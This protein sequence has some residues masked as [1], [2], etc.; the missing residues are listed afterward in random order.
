M[1]DLQQM[2]A[3]LEALPDPAFILSRSGKYI[4]VF[5]GRDARYYHDGTGLIGKYISDLVKPDKAEWF[6]EQI[7]RALES[8]KLLVEEYEL[9]N[10][11]V[12]GLPDEGPEDP[13]WFEGRI[14]ALDFQVDGEPLVLWVASNISERH[15]LEIRLRELS[16]TDQLTGLFNRRKL[17]HDL[18]LHFETFTRHA[19]PTTVLIFDV[20]NLKKINDSKGHHVGDEVL[21]A[22]ANTCRSELRKTDI[23]CRFGG[24][25]FVVCLPNTAPDR[26]LKFAERLQQDLRQALMD[27]SVGDI[28]ATI[29]LGA[30]N[31]SSEDRSYEDTLKR[32]D[33]ALYK[34]KR[35]GKDRIVTA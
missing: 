1:I 11:D 8:C 15:E 27:F 5:G 21:L 33:D 17:E 12:R 14:Q 32:A 2:R 19:V 28:A 10:R 22:V 3:V 29:S 4:A 20:D 13:I 25:E 7:G 35:L 23:A 31:I 34:A 16:D 18:A 9:S 26:A 24:D 30:A 6:L